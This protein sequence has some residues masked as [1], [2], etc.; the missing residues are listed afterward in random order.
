MRLRGAAVFNPDLLDSLGV[1]RTQPFGSPSLLPVV[2]EVRLPSLR[3]ACFTG[4]CV[5]PWEELGV[6][7][8]WHGPPQMCVFL[9]SDVSR[10]FTF[11]CSSV[12]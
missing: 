2:Q 7:T 5:W 1:P 4:V 10:A 9:G 8:P 6:C 12:Q 3:G 11:T